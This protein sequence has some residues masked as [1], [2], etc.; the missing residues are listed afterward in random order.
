MKTL[1]GLRYQ[2]LLD[3]GTSH[4]GDVRLRENAVEINRLGS[5]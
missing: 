3:P 1:F 2:D 5:V 4:A